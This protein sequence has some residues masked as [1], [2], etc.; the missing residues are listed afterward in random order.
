MINAR[1]AGLG[2]DAGVDAARHAHAANMTHFGN[3][4]SAKLKS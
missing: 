4:A 1:S 3:G 2:R